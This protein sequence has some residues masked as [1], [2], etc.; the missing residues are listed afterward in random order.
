MLLIA[1]APELAFESVI[2]CAVLVVL[3]S[4][5]P[6]ERLEGVSE[7]CGPSTLVSVNVAESAPWVA[8]TLNWPAVELEVRS[9]AVAEPFG[10]VVTVAEALNV[11][12]APLEPAVMENVTVAL[13][14]G[15]PSESFI[16]TCKGVG[17]TESTAL[18]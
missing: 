2:V 6:N 10:S 1:N 15:L 14:T 17:N 7:I 5:L 8:F 3:T 16:K 18:L 9:G 12:L 11:P 13:A 4:R